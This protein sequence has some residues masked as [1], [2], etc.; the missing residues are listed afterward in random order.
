MNVVYWWVGWNTYKTPFCMPPP[1]PERVHLSRTGHI[2]GSY[3]PVD[4]VIGL[5]GS[6]SLRLHLHVAVAQSARPP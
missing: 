1:P 2:G 4:T 3:M 5:L 6:T